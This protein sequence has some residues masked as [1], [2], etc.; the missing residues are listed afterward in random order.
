MTKGALSDVPPLTLLVVQLAVSVAFLWVV[1]G[2]QRMRVSLGKEAIQLGM[3]GLLNPG[4]AYT[5]SLLG[6]TLTTASMS[7]LLW[8]AEPILILGL[9]WLIL[10]E[11]LT[12]SLLA[13]SALAIFGVL[14]VAG[15]DPRAGYNSSLV[16]NLFVLAGVGCCALYTVLT[17]RIVSALEPL[18]VVA[19]QQTVAFV[20]ALA[21]WPIELLNGGSAALAA[22]PSS[23]WLWA[24]VSG[25][26]YYALAF[27]FYITG[28]KQTPAGLAGLFLNLIPIFGVAGA[29]VFLG[30]R[31]SPVQ[32]IGAILIL[33]AVVGITRLPAM[34]AETLPPLDGKTVVNVNSAG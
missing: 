20:W 25:I 15:I 28:L 14:L 34:R 31:L 5:F 27:W 6:L 26:L 8:A 3:I 4:I 16:G 30:E 18:V 9:A 12:P 32:W 7:T 24:V 1:V 19:L 22:I 33:A 11:R 13:L 17:R 29:Y 2:L 21:I 23:A 10:C